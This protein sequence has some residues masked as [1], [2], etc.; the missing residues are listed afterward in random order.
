MERRA[1]AGYLT[2]PSSFF[3]LSRFFGQQ[4]DPIAERTVL[5]YDY[6]LR[7]M[8]GWLHITGE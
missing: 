5:N 7:C 4:Q 3:P 8:L 1:H 2:C 6:A